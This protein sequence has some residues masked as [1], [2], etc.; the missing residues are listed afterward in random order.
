MDL[1]CLN[2]FDPFLEP[3]ITSGLR[4]ILWQWVPQLSYVLHGKN[5][6]LCWFKSSDVN[7]LLGPLYFLGEA[8]ENN[9]YISFPMCHSWSNRWWM[10]LLLLSSLSTLQTHLLHFS[11]LWKLFPTSPHPECFSAQLFWRPRNSLLSW[12]GFINDSCHGGFLFC[13]CCISR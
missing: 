13:S 2:F 10:Y 6:S 7:V 4:N 12:H 8:T 5:T 9:F 3:F 11:Y 1:S